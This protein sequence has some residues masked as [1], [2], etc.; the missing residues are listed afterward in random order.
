MGNQQQAA[1]IDNELALAPLY[2]FVPIKAI[3]GHPALAAFNGLGIQD[4]HT[5]ARLPG[6]SGPLA[7]AAHQGLVEPGP[8][9]VD[10]PAAEIL[11]NQRKGRKLS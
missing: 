9:P 3:G 5:R 11:V 2:F 4:G 1:G 6:R 7:L 10:L 8:A